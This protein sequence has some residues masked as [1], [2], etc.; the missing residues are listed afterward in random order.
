MEIKENILISIAESDIENGTLVLPI[1]IKEINDSVFLNN[2]SIKK[3]VLPNSLEKIGSKVFCGCQNLVEISLPDSIKEISE[4]T[5]SN[6]SSLENIN[7][8]ENIQYIGSKAFYKCELLA[9]II[10]PRN[11]H[12]IGSY[13]F[14]NCLNLTKI[15]ILGSIEEIKNGT[16]EN[17]Q[18]LK[19][20]I[21]PNTLKRIGIGAFKNC[22]NIK[23]LKMPGELKVIC[24]NAFWGCENLKSINFNAKLEEI[25]DYAFGD[26]KIESADLPKTLKRI[27]ITPF[28]L[29]HNLKK[30]QIYQLLSNEVL[31]ETNTKISEIIIDTKKIEILKSIKKIINI[32]QIIFIRYKDD[33][34]EVI[35]KVNKYYDKSYF[36]SIFPKYVVNISKI[37]RNDN[38]FNIYYWES[39]LGD[40]LK[41]INPLGII[42][43][44]PNINTIKAFANKR[45]YYDNVMK[46]YKDNNI[47]EQIAL[48][49][50]ITVFNGLCKKNNTNINKMI[51]DID[52]HNITK[53]FK[54]VYIKEFNQKFI[55]LYNKLLQNYPIKDINLIMPFLYNNIEKVTKLKDIIT[56]DQ[57]ETLQ[58]QSNL[59]CKNLEIKHYKI[60]KKIQNYDWLDTTN[61]I[62]LLW[63]IILAS[64]SGRDLVTA[65]LDRSVRSY[66]IKN[67][68]GLVIASCRVYYNVEEKYLLFNSIVLSQSFLNLGYDCNK[69]KDVL[70]ETVLASIEETL[71]FLNEK[72]AII[73]KVHVGISE[74]N[75]REQLLNRGVKII[76]QNI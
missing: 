72:E 10:I 17:C 42:A 23:E 65:D 55:D 29:C 15:T 76:E 61:P 16:F 31:D 2:K 18:S 41:E 7:L 52:L 39:I 14:S 26:T 48:I 6:C 51:N 27:G 49:K 64:V 13:A 54:D 35:D 57:I 24:M 1:G 62:N 45:K 36:E 59:E 74:N 32:D 22:K 38:I 56:I 3:I 47:E 33:S 40:E 68:K 43:L 60:P 12:K 20:I 4:E 67:D 25:G 19:E 8:S 5:F 37:I 9:E 63:G 69:I 46:D 53:Q 11:V 44:P 70:I 71:N 30:L 28:H 75:I 50:F 34:F 58:L 21:L 73:T 66:L